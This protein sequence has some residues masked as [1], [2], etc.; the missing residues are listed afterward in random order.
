MCEFSPRETTATLR[1][2]A[3]ADGFMHACAANGHGCAQNA[4][5]EAFGKLPNVS[6]RRT[7]FCHL[8]LT[9]PSQQRHFE[10]C[11]RREVSQF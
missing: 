3:A 2:D 8:Q 7:P 11:A 10:S 9:V 1:K 5:S 4:A 6:R